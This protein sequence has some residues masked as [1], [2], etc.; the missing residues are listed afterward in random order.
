MIGYHHFSTMHMHT[1]LALTS[2]YWEESYHTVHIIGRFARSSRLWFLARFEK[3]SAYKSWHYC[4]KKV[5][6]SWMYVIYPS[7]LQIVSQI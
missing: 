1:S 7:R 4:A 2:V 6:V 5:I 3:I